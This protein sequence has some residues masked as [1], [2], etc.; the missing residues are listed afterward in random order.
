M[1]VMDKQE[2]GRKAWEMSEEGFNELSQKHPGRYF[3]VEQP[4]VV[5]V[6][7]KRVDVVVVPKEAEKPVKNKG[8]KAKARQ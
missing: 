1:K 3:K 6:E 8:A 4:K 7:K 2:P 5:V